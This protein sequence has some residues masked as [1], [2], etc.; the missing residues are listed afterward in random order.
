[1]HTAREK[2]NRRISKKII[3]Q[4]C[5]LI[6]SGTPSSVA[7]SAVGVCYPNFTFWMLEGSKQAHQM[8]CPDCDYAQFF[9]EISAAEARTHSLLYAS[10]MRKAALGDRESTIWLLEKH[11]EEK[12]V[13]LSRAKAMSHRDIDISTTMAELEAL[14]DSIE[15][16]RNT[17]KS[18]TF[19]K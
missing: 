6:D 4:I 18:R 12:Q 9:N 16:Q 5:Q 14:I 17:T 7:A 2:D 1:M 19:S 10:L 15:A 11:Q 3:S 13:E 8:G